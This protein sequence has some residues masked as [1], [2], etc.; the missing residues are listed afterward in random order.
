MTP[1]E[2]SRRGVLKYVAG[3]GVIGVGGV[4]GLSSFA[5]DPASAQAEASANFEDATVELS[6][7]DRVEDVLINGTLEGSYE[8]PD[9]EISHATFDIHLEYVGEHFEEEIRDGITRQTQDNTSGS[10]TENVEYSLL[11]ETDLTRNHFVP[12]PN[13]PTERSH[14]FL[15]TVT[16]AVY[17][18]GDL[19]GAIESVT[20]KD[21]GTVTISVPPADDGGDTQAS[22]TLS[23][24]DF[25]YTVETS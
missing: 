2:P 6:E 5:A 11:A 3:A 7:G 25:G 15:L 24:A 10:F 22:V 19:D 14:E 20:A 18:N 16:F 17:G 4:A 13:G 21:H 1:T 12:S 8:A 23:T 9:D